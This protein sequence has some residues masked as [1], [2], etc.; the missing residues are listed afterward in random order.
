MDAVTGLRHGRSE[1]KQTV[2]LWIRLV[3]VHTFASS[4][5]LKP[6]CVPCGGAGLQAVLR[7]TVGDGRVGP[8][9]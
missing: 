1:T 7:R 3:T 8:D 9:A 6:E 5:T 2:G 4:V